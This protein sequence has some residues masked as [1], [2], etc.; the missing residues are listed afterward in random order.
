MGWEMGDWKDLSIR[1]VTSG[2]EITWP[3]AST[4]FYH[5]VWLRDCCYCELCGNGYSS[6]R[7][8]QPC[9]VPLDITPKHIERLNSNSLE[10]VWNPDDHRS[11]FDLD[12]LRRHSYSQEGLARRFHRPTV[13]DADIVNALP[14]V[15]YEAVV[16]GDSERLNLYRNLRDFGFVVIRSGPATEDGLEKVASLIGAIAESAYGKFFDLTPQSKIKTLGNTL[17]PV[18]PHTDEAFRHNPPGVNILHCI[19]PA[20]SGG[21]SVLVD[22]F[23]LGKVLRESDVKSFDCLVQQSQPNHRIDHA[24]DIDQRTRAPVFT[25]D[26]YGEIM[27][28]RFHPRSAAP[29]DVPADRFLDLYAANHALSKLMLNEQYQARFRLEAGD[30]VMFDNQRV[31][32]ARM[33]FS[34][35]NRKLKICNVS[36]ESFHEKLRLSAARLGFV[37]ES[38]QILSAGVSA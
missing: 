11:Q 32:H 10:I 22:G 29:F 16:V 20:D 14:C 25:L 26:E 37:E 12:W 19:R 34:D 1:Q 17:S 28:F 9:D 2:I 36:R 7:F 18:P 31:M 30:A 35:T 5:Y 13:W 4:S 8:L 27:G 33:G 38:E 6:S 21:E 15:D 24:S 3:D 23:K